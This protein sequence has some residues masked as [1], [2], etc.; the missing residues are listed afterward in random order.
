[1]FI[2]LRLFRYPAPPQRHHTHEQSI[3]KF[4]TIAPGVERNAVPARH[5]SEIA[6]EAVFA[7]IVEDV[8]L[9]RPVFQTL[10]VT[11][12]PGTHLR[13]CFV[14]H[15]APA[16][17]GERDGCRETRRTCADNLQ[18]S[19]PRRAAHDA[20]IGCFGIVVSLKAWG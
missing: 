16:R 20:C 5:P 19:L 17:A 14:D 11:L 2:F 8:S 13:G 1:M 10:V 12:K 18:H 4:V 7:E 9:G 3:V 6:G 15:D